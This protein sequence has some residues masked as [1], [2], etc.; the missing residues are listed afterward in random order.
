VPCEQVLAGAAWPLEFGPLVQYPGTPSSSVGG[1]LDEVAF[2]DRVMTQSEVKKHFDTASGIGP[3]ARNS[4]RTAKYIGLRSVPTAP[5]VGALR[6]CFRARASLV[7]E[8]LALRQQLVVLRRK[9]K[10]PHPVPVDRAFW[11]GSRRFGRGWPRASQ[12]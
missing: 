10:R 2:Y 9:R 7:A 12:S 4:D 8:N 6:A 1:V 5:T 3:Q 11:V